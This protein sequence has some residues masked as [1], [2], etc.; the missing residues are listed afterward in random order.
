MTFNNFYEKKIYLFVLFIPFIEFINENLN[1]I[2][3]EIFFYFLTYSII[4]FLFILFFF[5]FIDYFN[6]EKNNDNLKFLLSISFYIFFKFKF[7]KDFLNNYKINYDGEISIILIFLIIIF[8][9]IFNSYLII[10]KFLKIFL[11]C[12]LVII[13]LQLIY[14]FF[15]KNTKQPNNLFQVQSYF[16]KDEIAQIKNKRNIYY[17]VVD[18][19]T[20]LSNFEEKFNE[21][22]NS[23]RKFIKKKSLDY[24]DTKSAYTSTLTSFTSVLNLEYTYTESDIVFD[25]SKMFPETMKPHLVNNY[26]LFKILKSLNIDFF[27]EGVPHP[28]TCIQYNLDFCFH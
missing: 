5:F 25:R 3:I 9:F 13:G 16:S 21:K 27:W 15:V 24:Y 6:K 10:N 1:D 14:G 4:I 20:S 23:F 11:F 28:G 17:V 7:F 18:G 19:M 12:Y 26:P 2:T 8:L 22:N